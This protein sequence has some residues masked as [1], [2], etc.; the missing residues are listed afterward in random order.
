MWHVY[1]PDCRRPQLL[2][3]QQIVQLTNLAPGVIVVVLRCFA[4]PHPLTN[5]VRPDKRRSPILPELR[6]LAPPTASDLQCH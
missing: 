3:T 4:P 1:C 6:H 2:S 5:G